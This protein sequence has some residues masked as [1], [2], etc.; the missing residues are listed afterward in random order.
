MIYDKL[1]I[2]FLSTIASD[3]QVTTNSTIATYILDHL[4]TMQQ[5]GIK[6]MAQECNVGIASIS[7]FCKEIGLK[8]FV[9][10]KELIKTTSLSFEQI[11]SKDKADER[12]LDYARK[13]EASITQ[14]MESVSMDQV[15]KLVDDLV[16]YN[17]VAVFGLLKASGVAYNLQT[18]LL[19]SGKQVYT[20]IS[21]NEQLEYILNAGK[22]DLIIIFSYTGSYFDY[23]KLRDQKRKLY[24]PKIWLIG[25]DKEYPEYGFAKHKGY[26]SLDSSSVIES[27]RNKEIK[28]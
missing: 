2:V 10:L 24:A 6:E 15:N 7:R 18:D 27:I 22:D 4:D 21:Y 1:P 25:V 5:K 14:V 28:G 9:E 26:G 8:D 23:A 13:M 20:N 16:K 12:V 19:M 17:K 11:S 3:K